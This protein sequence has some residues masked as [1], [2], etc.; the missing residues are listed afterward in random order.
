M[1]QELYYFTMVVKKTV[2]QE[3]VNFE[4]INF[5]DVGFTAESLVNS[6][7]EENKHENRILELMGVEYFNSKL[8][9]MEFLSRNNNHSNKT[10]F[11]NISG[12]V[13]DNTKPI[14]R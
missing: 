1:E 6:T 4:I 9:F 7:N 3:F 12:N 2:N 10:M 5:G 13:L 14:K 11:R 8:D